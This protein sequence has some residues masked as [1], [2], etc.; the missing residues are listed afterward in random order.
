MKNLII[1]ALILTSINCNDIKEE[2]VN[3]EIP[4][5]RHYNNFH[6]SMSLIELKEELSKQ[7]YI[8]EP[9]KKTL[10]DP[11]VLIAKKN[12]FEIRAIIVV[13]SISELS[14]TNKSSY[15]FTSELQDICDAFDGKIHAVGNGESFYKNTIETY[16]R[17]EQGYISFIDNSLIEKGKELDKNEKKA[18]KTKVFNKYN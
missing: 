12:N 17:P 3:I 6:A 1:T 2:K 8:S 7:L 5:P 13:D 9:I 4:F 14:I 10:F 18:Q 16:V 15:D 11:K